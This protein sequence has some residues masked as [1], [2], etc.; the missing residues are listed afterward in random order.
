M[1]CIE[2]SNINDSYKLQIILTYTWDVLKQC[3]LNIL[4]IFLT[5]TWDV[6]KQKIKKIKKAGAGF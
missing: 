6:L 3:F 1:R 5:Y 4:N 2:T